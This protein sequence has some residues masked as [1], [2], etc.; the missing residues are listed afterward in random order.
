MASTFPK[1]TDSKYISKMDPSSQHFY[2]FAGA[3]ESVTKTLVVILKSS[4]LF[5]AL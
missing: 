4:L 1:G 2:I 3:V 5:P